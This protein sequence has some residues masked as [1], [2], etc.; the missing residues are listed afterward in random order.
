M[1]LW[2]MGQQGP[3][4]AGGLV[5]GPG[6]ETRVWVGALCSKLGGQ[7]SREAELGWDQT[8]LELRV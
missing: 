3:L 1:C 5:T 8:R 7:V 4:D 2:T 6:V